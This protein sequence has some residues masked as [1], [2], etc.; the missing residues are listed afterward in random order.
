MDDNLKIEVKHLNHLGII[1]ALFEDFGLIEKIDQLL[2]KTSNNQKISHGQAIMSMVMLGL[3]FTR[4]RLYRACDFFDKTPVENLFGKGVKASYFN[5]DVLSAAL[6]AIH[7]Y[8]CQRFFTDL[9][10]STLLENNLMTKFIRMDST[11]HHFFGRKYTKKGALKINYGHAKQR[12]DLPQLVQLLI[13]T[14]HGLPFWSKSYDGNINDKEIFVRSVK[15]IERFFKK[16]HYFDEYTII[17]DSA[18]YNKSFLLDKNIEGFW[19][20]RVPES[21]KIARH[22]VESFKD[23][24]KWVRINSSYKYRERYNKYAGVF[25]KWVIVVNRE[26]RF[27]EL[28]TLKRNLIRENETVEKKVK[29][30]QSR[31]FETTEALNMEFKRLQRQHPL[32]RIRLFSIERSR[33]QGSRQIGVRALITFRENTRRVNALK[34]KKGKFILA[35]NN[36]SAEMTAEKM[37]ELYSGQTPHMEG[38][39]KFLKDRS[40]NLSEVFLK[41]PNR[42]EALMSVMALSLF[43][44]NI[45]QMYLRDK[46]K[47]SNQFIPGRLGKKSQN[48]TLK[49]AF[50]LMEGVTKLRI[51]FLGKIKYQYKDIG[52]AQE[53]IINIFGNSAR[54]I[55]GFP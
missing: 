17:A 40:F 43:T 23:K 16:A 4:K 33:K 27:K 13:T 50:E 34:N 20:T 32:F 11:T 14:E 8:G 42:I 37:I 24:N 30:L 41:K 26:S 28:A 10:F 55:Y 7:E 51:D 3:G 2:P 47:E 18:L 29:Y 54:R 46:L 48:P 5:D 38:S 22:E 19:L 36:F 31:K 49:W 45:G 21:I 44:N 25:Q 35:T 1:S 52:S 53:T 12:H 9:S 39:F 6:D 15:H